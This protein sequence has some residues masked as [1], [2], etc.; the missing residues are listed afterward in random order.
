[1][2]F[3]CAL[4]A[5]GPLRL[6]AAFQAA[7]APFLFRALAA[8]GAAFFFAYSIGRI[9]KR[10]RTRR[11]RMHEQDSAA[12]EAL[13]HAA[14]LQFD[15]F[16]SRDEATFPSY[17]AEARPGLLHTDEQ[18][19]AFSHTAELITAPKRSGFGKRRASG[20]K[21]VKGLRHN[22]GRT[23]WPKESTE[24]AE[25]SGSLFIT[26]RRVVF[27][28]RVE[29][30]SVPVAKIREARVNRNSILLVIDNRAQPLVFRVAEKYR[31]SLIA[32]AAY[33]M[34]HLAIAGKQARAARR[35]R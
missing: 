10:A 28:G 23:K 9:R 29:E 30:V 15:L 33:R 18:C 5:T 26:T 12:E 3:C 7:G 14:Q 21:I 8:G 31:A 34:A 32:A 2:Y 13:R 4:A 19:Y 24:A 25:D 1:M 11:S 20:L 17:N 16:V 6:A 35:P 22:V 27:D